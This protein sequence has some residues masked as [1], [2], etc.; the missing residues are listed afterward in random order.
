MMDYHG[1]WQG[2]FIVLFGVFPVVVGAIIGVL[3]A[4]R[5]GH[6]G[7]KLITSAFLTAAVKEAEHFAPE[8]PRL[9]TSLNNLAAL[10]QAQGKYAEAE[11]LHKRSLAIREKA[12]GPEH[13]DVAET[14][15][16]L[17]GLYVAQGKYVDA[18]PLYKRALAIGEKALGPEHPN[19]ATSLENYAAL[20]RSTERTTE[21]TKM[22]A[23]AKAIRAK[24]AR[25][26]PAK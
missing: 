18:E 3:W 2:F 4:W 9:A 26:N 14:L 21:A 19:V 15:N 10:Y 12:L 25:E 17:A 22:E 11:P 13:P 24:H 1:F 6:R 16:N 5:K 20:L 8:D 7:T 23:R